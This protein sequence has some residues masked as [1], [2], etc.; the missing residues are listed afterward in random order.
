MSGGQLVVTSFPGE[1]RPSTTPP[2]AHKRAAIVALSISI[3]VV[4]APA[5]AKWRVHLQQGVNHLDGIHND[6]VVGPANAMTHEFK[7]SRI[8]DIFSW[9]DTLCAGPPVRNRDVSLIRILLRSLIICALRKNAYVMAGNA[10]EQS[11][12]RCY[13]P[14]LDMTL[15]KIGVFLQVFRRRLIAS[16]AREA[17]GTDQGRDV[18]SKRGWRIAA[19]L[20][21]AFLRSHGAMPNQICGRPQDHGVRV[22]VLESVLAFEPPGEHDGKGDFIQLDSPPVGLTVNPEVL[23][24]TSVL[25][26]GDIEIDECSQGCDTISGG[27]HRIRAVDHVARPHQVVTALVLIAYGFAPGDG[28]RGDEGAGIRLVFMSTEQAEARA[29][30][31]TSVARSLLQRKKVCARSRP[32][33]RIPLAMLG[34]GSTQGLK[35]RRD[36]VVLAIAECQPQ[37]EFARA[38]QIQFPGECNVAVGGV[39]E[40]PVHLKV[41]GQ[42]GPSVAFPNVTTRNAGERNRGRQGQP[43]SFFFGNQNRSARH[44]RH[45][46]AVAPAA[47]LKM[48]RAQGEKPRL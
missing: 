14:A 37:G 8:H 27:E 31:V 9:K 22:K 43:C 30:Q 5:R 40:L 20:F 26:L 35:E 39:I 46:A 12:L 19:D 24:E 34:E 10:R 18:R 1:Q 3:V 47:Y 11:P 32:L 6:W 38:G 7:K 21:P 42:V 15:Q 45:I 4:T 29:V 23:G 17:C 33:F 41:A 44:P 13:R 28:K 48:R 16:F 25:L 36:G 2:E